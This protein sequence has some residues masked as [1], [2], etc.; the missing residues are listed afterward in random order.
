MTGTI[1]IVTQYHSIASPGMMIKWI[2]EDML[3]SPEMMAKRI[4]NLRRIG[5]GEFLKDTKDKDGHPNGTA[6]Q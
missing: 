3:L 6:E 2:K 1:V 4:T 5:L